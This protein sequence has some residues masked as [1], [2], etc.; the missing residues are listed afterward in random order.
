MK[1]IR[2]GIITLA[3]L[4]AVALTMATLLGE[5]TD[6]QVSSTLVAEGTVYVSNMSGWDYYEFTEW[7]KENRLALQVSTGTFSGTKPLKSVVLYPF[8]ADAHADNNSPYFIAQ[9]TV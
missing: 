4:T 2:F 8:F 6:A 5:K 9:G 3:V 1:A 7:Q